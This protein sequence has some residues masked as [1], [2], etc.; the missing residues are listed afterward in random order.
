MEQRW[1]ILTERHAW[2]WVADS[3]VRDFARNNM[4]THAASFAF[5]AFLSV[6]PLALLGMAVLGF[7][8]RGRPDLQIK[9]VNAVFAS[10]P[11]FGASFQ[12][13]LNGVI[14]NRL[15]LGLIGFIGLF[16]S[17]TGFTRA[18]DAGFS[19]IWRTQ[20]SHFWAWRLRGLAVICGM[21]LVGILGFLVN[22]LMR[23]VSSITLLRLA[24]QIIVALA[25]IWALLMAIYVIVPRRRIHLKEVMVGAL[26]AAVLWYATQSALQYYLS[27]L[28]K[29]N[30]I[31]G[32][33]GAVLSLLLWLY[34]GGYIIFYGGELNRS[35]YEK[36]GKSY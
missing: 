29:T 36:A 4:S 8:F 5:Y 1:A 32:I 13:G 19:T 24:L 31:Y 14:A 17:G 11:K 25:L 10:L 22:S 30:Q 2:L 28:S 15:S 33:L 20:S 6:F 21:V 9:A 35:L 12:D 16:W 34:V 7:V 23:L 3:S 26:V 18:L 27:T